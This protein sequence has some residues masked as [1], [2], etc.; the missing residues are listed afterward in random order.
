M[1]HIDAAFHT[2]GESQYVD[3][4][5]QPAEL[6]HAAVF[7]SPVA[8]G[9]IVSLDIKAA[10][11]HE[12]VA[13]VFLAKD[14]PGENQ[15]G[16]LIPDEAL[17]AEGEVHYIGEP[18]ALVVADTFA[19]AHKAVKK[20]K[21]EVAPLPVITDPRMAFDKGQIIGAARTFVMGDVDRV[22]QQ[23]DV[24]VEGRCDIGGQEHL[25]LETQR[26]RAIPLEGQGLRLY[27][28]TQSPYAVQRT[29]AR[30]LG[31]AHHMV[32][33]DV[34]RLGGGF[35]GKED[36]ATA[37]SC[38]AALAAWHTGKPVELV[39]PRHHDMIMTGKRHPYS[40]DFKIGLNKDGKIL[41]YDVRY[42]QNS[43]AAA[44]LS[45]AVLERTLFH[46]TNAYFIPNVR[47]F[48]VC[49]RTNLPPNTAF[50]GFGGPQGMFVIESAIA[51][52]AEKLGM[53]R[54]EIQYKNLLRGK[55]TF[56]YGQQVHDARS[57][58][59]WD[60]A[61]KTYRLTAMQKRVEKFNKN[62][63]ETKKGLA[64]MPI[65]FGISFTATF[66]NQAGALVHVYTDGS[67]SVSMGGVEMGQ[68]L[69]TNIA[70]IAAKSFGIREERVK[71]ESTN[72]TRIANMSPSAASATTDLNGNATL[73]ATGEIL[74]R[75][76]S[77]AVKELGLSHKERLTIE[78]E[79]LL[80][81]GKAT[82]WDWGKLVQTAYLN[83]V[84]LSAHGFYAT[85]G[86]WFDK[87]RE[88][89][90]PFAYHVF[91][92]AILEVTVDCLRGTYDINS[93]KIVHDLGRPMNELVDRGQIE[94]GLAQG[95]G[96]MTLEELKF[97]EQGRFWS[98]S[99]ASYK[100]P[101]VYFMPD[102]LEVKLLENV[103]NPASP[104]GTKAVGEPPLMYGIG[105]F[106]ALR[107]AMRAFRPDAEFA[108]D[109]P[110]TP[111]RVLMQLHADWVDDLTN[112][113]SKTMGKEATR[114]REKLPEKL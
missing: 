113:R 28:S 101:D 79:Q 96:W 25:Y 2:R 43:G 59:T 56:P 112:G 93:V 78:D 33:V 70:K 82:G 52:A 111:E 12:G 102:N 84:G 109:S 40:A 45:T 50:R 16:A 74:E 110:L 47:A 51:K 86:I 104:Y 75:L 6:L 91:G 7:G 14:I 29:A 19:N 48:A 72:T 64:V 3:D 9:K 32:E 62:H 42:Y 15:I 10:L 66:L 94:G 38:L 90:H 8:H 80:Y 27:S 71:V 36:Q 26:A 76:K 83:R 68:G 92:A 20:I 4:M 85:P 46:S 60:E 30:I 63:F 65:C 106:F 81:A 23:C 61:A 95:L 107:A 44:D 103:D 37:W 17:L 88:K 5:P 97:D 39:L 114:K 108:F 13:G 100:A 73:I 53:P 55:D 34:K 105:V 41:A 67:V 11:A 54:E 98:K 1:N 18:I 69:I 22:W 57:V 49:C 58:H 21:I 77:F 31:V 35:G 24:V 99:L 87:G 89:G